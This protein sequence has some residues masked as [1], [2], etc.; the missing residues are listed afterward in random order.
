LPGARPT[1]ISQTDP[2]KKESLTPPV[3]SR[4]VGK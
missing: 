1:P 4:A 2:N 3:V